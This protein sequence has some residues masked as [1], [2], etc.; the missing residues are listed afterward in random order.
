MAEQGCNI[1]FPRFHRCCPP[2]VHN[3]IQSEAWNAWWKQFMKDN[4]KATCPE[5]I[6]ELDLLM[7]GL[8]RSLYEKCVPLPSTG[9]LPL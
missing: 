8:F 5:I 9:E 7:N 3:D 2:G 6:V 4:P 1:E